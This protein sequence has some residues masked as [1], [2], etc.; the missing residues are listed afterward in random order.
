[1]PITCSLKPKQNHIK[2]EMLTKY[3]NNLCLR[4]THQVPQENE[5]MLQQQK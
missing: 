5:T 2:L 1:M 4:K 3:A